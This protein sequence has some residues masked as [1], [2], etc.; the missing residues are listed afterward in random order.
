[1][2]GGVIRTVV[3]ITTGIAEIDLAMIAEIQTV[4]EAEVVQGAAVT[5]EAELF[6]KDEIVGRWLSIHETI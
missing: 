1:M 3:G 6:R 2:I 4:G 5:G